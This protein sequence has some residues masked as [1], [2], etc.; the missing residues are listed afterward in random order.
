M[1]EAARP[2]LQMA[3]E[4]LVGMGGK[5]YLSGF[6]EFSPQQWREHFGD[7]W[8]GF[9]A[10]KQRYDPDDRLNPGFVRW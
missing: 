8:E 7:R 10:L 1:W 3:S 5:R 9:A 2:R 6:I 4:L